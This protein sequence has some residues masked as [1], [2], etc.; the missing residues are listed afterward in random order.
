[1]NTKRQTVWLVSMLSLMVVLSVYY[2]FT[3]NTETPDLASDELTINETMEIGV[4]EVTNGLVEG[5]DIADIAVEEKIETVIPSDEQVLTQ[6]N[7]K[8]VSGE[9]Y[10]A[11]QQ[12][13][14]NDVLSLEYERLLNIATD[15]EKDVEAVT[16]AQNDLQLIQDEQEII[17]SLEEGLSLNYENAIISKESNKWKVT[18]QSKKLE[19]SEAVSIIDKV[20]KELKARADQVVVTY[21][22]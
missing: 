15:T 4:D 2:L 8:V 1:M 22:P 6:L 10:F 18:V 19:K 20:M 9:A 12:M 13:E 7:A 17:N 5:Q 14:R 21:I 11:A 16:Q 3:D